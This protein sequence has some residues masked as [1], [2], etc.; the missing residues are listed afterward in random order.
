MSPSTDAAGGG[1]GG[2]G[3]LR[4]PAPLA[5]LHVAALDASPHAMAPL[6]TRSQSAPHVRTPTLGSGLWVAAPARRPL[7][8]PAPPSLPAPPDLPAAAATAPGSVEEHAWD[9]ALAGIV[10][11]AHPPTANALAIWEATSATNA[12]VVVSPHSVST[13]WMGG[14]TPATASPVSSAPAA[15]SPAAAAASNATGGGH[16]A[17][18]RR[19]EVGAK[20]LR[21]GEG[22]GGGPPSPPSGGGSAGKRASP[23]MLDTSRSG[24]SP[25]GSTTAR[26]ALPT[27][28]AARPAV[29]HLLLRT[30][31][32]RP[33]PRTMQHTAA[34]TLE[35]RLT[36]SPIYA[37]AAAGAIHRA[38]RPHP[39]RDRS[40]PV[41]PAHGVQCPRD[42]R[43]R[44]ALA[45]PRSCRR[46]CTAHRAGAVAVTGVVCCSDT[47]R[48]CQLT[49]V[50]S[51]RQ[52]AIVAR[53]V[54][55]VRWPALSGSSNQIRRRH[56]QR[57]GAGPHARG[58]AVG[59]WPDTWRAAADA[60]WL[61]NAPEW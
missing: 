38:R 41:T 57:G 50:T 5:T 61:A 40:R 59:C 33:R 49:A 17:D 24:S 20:Y 2:G 32:P 29:D 31:A 37:V 60:T 52:P 55:A 11:D 39:P 28:A 7:P 4:G 25:T 53:N 14:S 54:R 9:A 36:Q 45:L 19:R 44:D 16:A 43:Y 30:P 35:R 3:G 56:Q 58:A 48:H 22:H 21:S 15:P 1:G 51:R 42:S 26:P 10:I 23:T 27:G 8:P 13:D 47:P 46:R 6:S 12:P 18:Y 34:A